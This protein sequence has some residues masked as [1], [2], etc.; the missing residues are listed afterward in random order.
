MLIFLERV[1]KT[2]E[3]FILLFVFVCPSILYLLID[4]VYLYETWHI[5]LSCQKINS[6]AEFKTRCLDGIEKA[7]E[8][9]I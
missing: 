6:V 7:G 2:K 8:L 5:L 4:M 1:G 3:A 9:K